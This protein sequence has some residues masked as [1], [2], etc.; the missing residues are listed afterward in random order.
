MG[1]NLQVEESE[2]TR[3]TSELVDEPAGEVTAE[4]GAEIVIWDL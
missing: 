3:A 1:G 4:D 2:L